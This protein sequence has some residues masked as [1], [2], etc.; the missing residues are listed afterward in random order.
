MCNVMSCSRG[1]T[2]LH[3][4]RPGEGAV[5]ENI[6]SGRVKCANGKNEHVAAVL[7]DTENA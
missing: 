7:E 2:R 5:R 4:E 6:G 3:S 1:V